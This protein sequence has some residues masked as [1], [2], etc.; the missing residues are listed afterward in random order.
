MERCF[1]NL[2]EELERHKPK[3]VFLLGKQVA[4]FVARHFL[5]ERLQQDSAFGYEPIR[6]NGCLFVPVYH[7]SYMLVYQR[8]HI[9]KY[10]SSIRSYFP[11]RRKI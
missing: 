4:N 10:I 6:F 11:E 1:P 9:D 5:D 7:P 2:E 3:V 8:Q